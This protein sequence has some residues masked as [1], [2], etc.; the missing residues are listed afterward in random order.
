[1]KSLLTIFFIGFIICLRINAQTN[2]LPSSGASTQNVETIVCIRHGEKPPGGLGQLTCR[3][4]NRALA[5]PAVLLAKYGSPQFVFAANPTQKA[6]GKDGK[7]GHFYIRPLM[8]I[9][10]TAVRCGL[11]VNVQF[12]SKEIKDLENELQKPVYKSAT[13]FIAWEHVLLDDF[14][15]A[16]VKDYR[17][18]PTQVPPWPRDDYDTIFVVRITRSEG[19]ES[20]S[21][22]IDYENL[23]NLSDA[24]PEVAKGLGSRA[25]N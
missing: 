25:L 24:C 10:P 6:D 18:D 11:P 12:G 14:V 5:L 19:R 22:T 13:I 15:K 2:S 21:F 7:E 23:N 17:G 8:T 3:G 9:E 16:L 20:V 4:L 1:M